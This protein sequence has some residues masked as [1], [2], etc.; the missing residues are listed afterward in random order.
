MFSTGIRS[1]LKAPQ[2][3]SGINSKA[4][5]RQRKKRSRQLIG[6]NSH[7]LACSVERRRRSHPPNVGAC[8][9]GLLGSP[10]A[11]QLRHLHR[12]LPE[13]RRGGHRVAGIYDTEQRF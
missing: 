1:T 10:H 4:T 5:A 9:L 12:R 13:D 11:Y 3:S 2:N 7:S 6:Q 8:D